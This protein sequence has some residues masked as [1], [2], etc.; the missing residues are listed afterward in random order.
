MIIIH[1]GGINSSPMGLF[2]FG[3]SILMDYVDTSHH[4]LLNMLF[5]LYSTQQ[6]NAKN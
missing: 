4:L 1:R 5:D 3:L 2:V 6:K